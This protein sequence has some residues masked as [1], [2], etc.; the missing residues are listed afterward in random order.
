MFK[1]SD[2][3]KRIVAEHFGS[4]MS[5]RLQEAIDEGDYEFVRTHLRGSVQN[6]TWEMFR[7]TPVVELKVIDAKQIALKAIRFRLELEIQ[8]R[9][10]VSELVI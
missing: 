5:P 1:F 4:M 10:R 8:E 3:F 2:H 9:G 6:I 7:N